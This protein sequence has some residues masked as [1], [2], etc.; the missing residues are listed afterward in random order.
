MVYRPDLEASQWVTPLGFHMRLGPAL[1]FAYTFD[2]GKFAKLP[3]AATPDDPLEFALGKPYRPSL[4]AARSATGET[5]ALSAAVG[6]I[7]GVEAVVAVQ[8]FAFIAGSLGVAVGERI[9]EVAEAALERG[10]ALVIFTAS[11]GARMQEGT[12]SLMQMARA[13]VAVDRLRRARL[14]YVVVLTD[15][16]IGGVTASYAMLGDVQIIERGA[17]VGLTGRRVIEQTI[18]QKLPDDYQSAEFL[19]DRGM[20]DRIVSRPQLPNV[21]GSTLRLL[22]MERERLSAA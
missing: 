8:D 10:A 3:L 16:T 2:G 4:R 20:A 17:R 7:G 15:P 19:L 13:T 14:P 9:V 1:R 5:E 21:L 12:L 6:K 11:G 18:R 22:M